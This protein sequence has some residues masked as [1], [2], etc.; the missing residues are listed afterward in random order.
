MLIGPWDITAVALAA[1]SFAA[2]CQSAGASLFAVLWHDRMGASERSVRRLA[3][4]TACLGIGIVALRTVLEPAHLAGD[5]AGIAD[6]SL[7]IMVLTSEIGVAALLRVAGLILIATG[8]G[9]NRRGGDVAAIIGATVCC[10][11]YALT[12]HTAASPARALLLPLLTAHL[13]LAAF[14]FGALVPLRMVLRHETTDI[15]GAVLADYS[16]LAVWLV[17]AIALAG[18]TMLCVLADPLAAVPASGWGR[19]TLLKLAVFTALMGFAALNKQRLVPRLAAG[20]A[21]AVRALR[22]SI[23]CEIGLIL[24]VFATTAVITGFFAPPGAEAAG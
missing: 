10:L 6:P 9:R 1:F 7:Q 8:L 19:L 20:D 12:G 22:T 4:R 13:L 11:S 14:W 23:A 18:G 15:A 5:A 16:R 17:P 24:L 2:V 3:G 21:S